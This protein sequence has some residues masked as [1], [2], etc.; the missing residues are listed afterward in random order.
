MYVGAVASRPAAS[1]SCARMYGRLSVVGRLHSP[2]P[3]HEI[4]EQAG[5]GWQLPPKAV[6]EV[7]HDR[8]DP[9]PVYERMF[10]D[11]DTESYSD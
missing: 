4:D 2:V 1:S 6:I 8:R 11:F 5:P 10:V 9:G 7:V 3:P